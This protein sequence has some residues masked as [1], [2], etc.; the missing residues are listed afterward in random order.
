MGSTLNRWIREH[1]I[2]EFFLTESKTSESE[3]SLT[4]AEYRV[5]GLVLGLAAVVIFVVPPD[6]RPVVTF[7]L[8]FVAAQ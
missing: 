8:V 2:D 6:Y 4:W 1:I 3:P 5:L 7:G